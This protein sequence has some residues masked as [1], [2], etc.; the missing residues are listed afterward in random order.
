M[1][2]LGIE[3]MAKAALQLIQTGK[4]SKQQ[5]K[6][7]NGGWWKS[8]ERKGQYFMDCGRQRVWFNPK[9]KSAIYEDKAVSENRASQMCQDAI[10]KEALTSPNFHYFDTSYTVHH[11]RKAVTY[12]QGFDVKNAFGAKL[13]Y[14]FLSNSAFWTI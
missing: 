4:C 9:S 10:R 5:I 12:I 11:P 1:T 7:D 2:C 8:G 3:Q 13:K 6:D 14:C